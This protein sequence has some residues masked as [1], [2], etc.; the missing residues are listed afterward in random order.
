[1]RGRNDI[2]LFAFC[3]VLKLRILGD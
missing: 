3:K 2:F 1:M